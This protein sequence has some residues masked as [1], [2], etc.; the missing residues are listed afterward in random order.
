M[1]HI[2]AHKNKQ[3][4]AGQMNT[5]LTLADYIARKDDSKPKKTFD[6]WLDEPYFKLGDRVVTRRE[7]WSPSEIDCA[8]DTWT[9]ARK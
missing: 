8:K 2:P 3:N 9:E 6:E 7:W 1:M 4:P 5:D